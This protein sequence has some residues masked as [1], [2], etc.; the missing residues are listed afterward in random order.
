VPLEVVA[1]YG[2]LIAQPTVTSIPEGVLLEG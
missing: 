2:S 1:K